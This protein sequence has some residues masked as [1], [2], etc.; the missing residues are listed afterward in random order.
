MYAVHQAIETRLLGSVTTGQVAGT[1]TGNNTFVQMT[2]LVVLQM[3]GF[4][5][6]PDF[7][8]RIE[9]TMINITRS[10]T[11]FLRQPVINSIAG[12]NSSDPATYIET[13]AT[14]ISYPTRYTYSA[15]VLWGPYATSL[16][17]CA[18]CVCLGFWM[19]VKNGVAADMSFSQI[20]VATRNPAIDR[21]CAGADLGGIPEELEHQVR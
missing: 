6:V 4:S 14:I 1:V 19:L 16:A 5:L 10:L 9:N 11:H 15:S 18:F 20:L 13:N 12:S 21:I 2:S 17:G 3:Q 8:Q 7:A